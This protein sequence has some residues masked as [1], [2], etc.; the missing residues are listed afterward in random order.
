[1]S[2][3][4]D[5]KALATKLRAAQDEIAVA[6]CGNGCGCAGCSPPGMSISRERGWVPS[7]PDAMS[8]DGSG[9]KPYQSRER[10]RQCMVPIASALTTVT[11]G[12]ANAQQVT[13]QPSRGCATGYYVKVKAVDAQNPQND[14]RVLVGRVFIGTDCVQDCRIEGLLSDF[15]DS[16]DCL[17]CPLK[18][19]FGRQNDNEEIRIEITNINAAGD[20]QVQIVVWG[21][22]ENGGRC[23]A[24]N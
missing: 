14:Q 11:A 8:P 13:I 10:D 17:G 22:C 18:V 2:A 1:M 24:G 21:F 12:A 5:M 15:L 9:Y 16:D 23:T 7:R 3:Q 19:A 20:I 4:L 6:G